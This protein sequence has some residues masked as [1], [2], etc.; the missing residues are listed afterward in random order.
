MRGRPPYCR[1][2]STEPDALDPVLRGDGRPHRGIRKAIRQPGALSWSVLT[3][4]HRGD[5]LAGVRE[6]DFD[7]VACP[8]AWIS[9]VPEWSPAVPPVA[10][11]GLAFGV[12]DRAGH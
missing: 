2:P 10:A 7:G 8:Y 3:A 9:A 5:G 12:G 11:A 1:S 4:R 6:C